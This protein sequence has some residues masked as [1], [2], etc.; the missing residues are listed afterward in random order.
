M[1]LRGFKPLTSTPFCYCRT[2]GRDAIVLDDNGFE[3]VPSTGL[4]WD[5]WVAASATRSYVLGDSL[6]DWL[7]RHGR[8][9]GFARSEFD[10]RTDFR[11]FIFR[12]GTEFERAVVEYLR[13]LG[14]GE[15]RGVSGQDCERAA[16]R[17]LDLALATWDAMADGVAIIDQGVLRDP[18]HRTYG[19][20]D[21]LVRSDVLAQLFRGAL[22]PEEATVAAPDLDIGAHYVVVDI[23][24]TTLEL[25]TNGKLSSSGSKL[26]Y[27]TQLHIYNRALARLQGY[28]A[29]RMFLLGRGW[30]QTTTRVDDCMDRLGG[31]EH[32][33]VVSGQPLSRWADQ[34]ASWLRRMRRH[35][36]SWDV[37]PVPSVDALRP[38]TGDSGVWTDAVK[39][40]KAEGRDLTALYHVGVQHRDK[41]TARGLT[42]WRDE[43]VTPRSLGM[44]GVTAAR[45]GALLDVNRTPGPG[46]RPPRVGAARS[47]W[48][49]TPPVEFYVDFETVSDLDDD[50]SAI[51]AR[52]GQPLVF[53]IGCGHLENGHWQFSCFVV[54][55][56][57]EPAEATTIE[58]WLDHMSEVRERIDPGSRPRV[59]HWSHHERSSL[60][61]AYN[62]AVKR[63]GARG[64]LWPTPRWF[65][66]LKHVIREEPV[67]VRGAHGFGLKAITNALH[68]QGL[69]QTR[70]QTGPTDGLGAMVGA[71]W[72]Q[73][74]VRAGRASRLIDLDLMQ[75]IREYNEVDCKAMMEIVRYLRANH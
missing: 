75:E 2:M 33:E 64:K 37:L 9:K 62:S 24:Y 44:T 57:T 38:A 7:A 30:K 10:E 53:M 42:D 59:I 69:V 4:E 47:Q 8:S 12:K 19:L 5:E 6:S 41:A 29:P 72:C 17:D 55:Q 73:A 26:A 51:P 49:V 60:E 1:D 21:L 50:F 48:I 14:M 66:F 25:R 31:I 70:W 68:T 35:G 45:L 65:D 28:L 11:G 32:D 36:Q 18:E 40:I 13:S 67:A 39:R 61:K 74:E 54:D 15:V 43:R 52:G 3:R 16:A 58:Q 71:W 20:P 22:S 27:M 56:L 46:V 34:A 23:K 63:H